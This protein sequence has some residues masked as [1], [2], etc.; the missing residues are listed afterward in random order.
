MSLINDYI[1]QALTDQRERELARLA[2]FNWQI[3]QALNG[4]VSWWRRLLARRRQRDS[5]A[6]RGPAH[7]VDGV[8]RLRSNQS[9]EEPHSSEPPV[10]SASPAR[11]R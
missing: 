1:Y 5:T 11:R 2:E 7:R 6:A 9:C 10:A 4:R 8:Q 3:R